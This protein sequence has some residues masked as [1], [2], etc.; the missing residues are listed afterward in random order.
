MS[1]P[2]PELESIARRW[3]EAMLSGQGEVMKNLLS[4]SLDALYCGTSAAELITGQRLQDGLVGHIAE[5]VG[6]SCDD[7]EIYAYDFGDA[8]WAHWQGTIRNEAAETETR[9]RVTLVLRLETGVWKVHHVHNSFT[10]ENL[11]ELGIEHF[12]FEDLI[13]SA[14]EL[15]PLVHRSGSATVMF[16]DIVGSS[17]LAEALGDAR[18]AIAVS[19]HVEQIG[20]QVASEDGRLIKSLGDGT[21]ST[22]MSAGAG[23]RAARNIQ[24]NL[25]RSTAEPCLQIRIGLHTG[26]VIDA[27]DDFFGTVVN[28]AARVAE[29]AGPGEITVSDATRMMVGADTSYRFVDT[30]RVSL[31]GLEG[32]HVI[33]RL[34]WRE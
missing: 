13:E 3:M 19:D 15:D 16:T 14:A 23:L 25:S 12:A 18:W 28:K 9:G 7:G 30:V 27:G 34:D 20:G 11:T 5:I 31:K 2:S 26:D 6:L 22:F 1:G 29:T 17:A 24:Q 21:M 33:H 32:E 8:G 10:T 4:P